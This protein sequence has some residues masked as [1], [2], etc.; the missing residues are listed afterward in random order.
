[1]RKLS[2]V[3]ILL[4]ISAA[5]S[6]QPTATVSPPTGMESKPATGVPASPTAATAP[7]P[8]TQSPWSPGAQTPEMWSRDPAT[9][10]N[11]EVP[12]YRL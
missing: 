2:I 8:Y 11:D 1:M 5:C 6:N 4:G 12:R 7:H 3:A 10:T 9:G